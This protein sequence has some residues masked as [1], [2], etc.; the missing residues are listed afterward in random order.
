[1][2][3]ALVKRSVYYH[4]CFIWWNNI[5]REESG[6]GIY[7]CLQQMCVTFLFD[8]RLSDRKKQGDKK[9]KMNDPFR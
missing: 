5:E 9:K 1:M 2:N 6:V 4:F 7:L 3:W 8:A